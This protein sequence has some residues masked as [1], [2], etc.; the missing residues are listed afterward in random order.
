MNKR[1]LGSCYEKAAGIYLIEQ[2]YEILEYNYRC[3]YGEIDLVAR[4]GE[5][6][7]FCEVKYRQNQR[8]GTALEAVDL[9][10]QRNI[11]KVAEYYLMQHRVGDIPCR[12]DVVGIEKNTFI[13][14]K[15]AFEG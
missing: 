15:N 7:V 1:K 3:R 13:L 6:L 9:R 8:S 4:D 10:K 11:R 5:D 14:I 12:F 2:G